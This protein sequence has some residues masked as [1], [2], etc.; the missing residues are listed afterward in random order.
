MITSTENFAVKSSVL[1]YQE[2][3]VTQLNSSIKTKNNVAF[4]TRSF[5]I[6]NSLTMDISSKKRLCGT[7]DLFSVAR[8]FLSSIYKIYKRFYLFQGG[9]EVLK[10][11]YFQLLCQRH[12]QN[13]VEHLRWS[14]LLKAVIS[15]Q[16]KIHLTYLGYE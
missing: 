16:K 15:F 6:N 12:I 11:L 5:L 1:Y 9:S 4:L 3:V 2:L 14:F 8:G 13:L 10:L 7:V